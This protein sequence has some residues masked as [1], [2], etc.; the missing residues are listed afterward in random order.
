MKKSLFFPLQSCLRASMLLMVLFLILH[1]NKA[2][3]QP[4]SLIFTD[5][6]DRDSLGDNWKAFNSW[7]IVNGYA[8]NYINGFGGTLRTTRHFSSPSY[9][10]ETAAAGFTNSYRRE[11]RVT[12]GQVNLAS[13]SAYVL[14]Y[15]PNSGGQLTLSR[16]TGNI[17]SPQPLDEVIVYPD[18]ESTKW[19]KFKIEKYKSGLIQVFMDKG[20]GYSAVPLLEAVDSTYQQLGHFGWQ[21]DTQTGAES[22]YVD[23]IE[24][25]KPDVEK[26]AI[27]E[28]PA[29]DNLITQVS[30]TS[31]RPYQVAKLHVGVA[32]FTDRLYAITAVPAYLEGASFIQPAMDDKA[33]TT[34]SFLTMFIKKDAI[35]Y[36]GYDP[37]GESIPAWLKSWEK[38]GDIIGTTDPGSS[39]LEIY[40]K[41]VQYGQVY[42]QPLI[43]GGNL[44]SP[45][46]GS[47]I[48]YIVAAVEKPDIAILEA[49]DAKL[50]GAV[51]AT[52]HEGY[53]GAG[54]VD[55]INLD[56]GYVEWT[57][58]IDI[59]GWY[60]LSF[61]Y[62]IG[63][64]SDR[65]LAIQVDEDSADIYTFIPTY[66]WESWGF[67]Q[68]NSVYLTRGTH[69]IKATATGASGPNMDYLSLSYATPPSVNPAIAASQAQKKVE[70]LPGVYD[71]PALAY[72]NPFA[73]S[74]TISY[75]LK[76][77]LPVSLT[78]YDITGKKVSVLVNGMQEAG[79]HNIPFETNSL[80]KGL[81]IYRLNTGNHLNVGKIIKQ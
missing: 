73:E 64:G 19:A 7:S 18:L 12:F 41:V 27:K 78:I 67:Y 20:N 74:T 60:A 39:Y 2:F 35:V 57:A 9:I 5:H 53:S 51:V 72:P 23:W 46:A 55:Y 15:T 71:K 70:A 38:T 58:Q 22:F 3:A 69:K 59:P 4:D 66:S 52:N 21:E 75:S 81:Y 56:D 50:A 6:F 1:H 28:K 29:E 76:E 43:L 49:E 17:Y 11:F 36:I 24:V 54:F 42:P 8:Y 33:D 25:R 40:R 65:S 48:N 79:E 77:K 80:K 63:R 45:A 16:A 47:E 26:P 61:S 30:A 14:S 34:G 68:G 44:E 32:A 62:S 13:D 37:R 31:G 10:L